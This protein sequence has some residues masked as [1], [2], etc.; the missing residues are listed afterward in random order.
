ML[1]RGRFLE[2]GYGDGSMLL[3]LARKGFVG[4]GF[5]T[6]PA[7]QAEAEEAVVRATKGRIRLLRTLD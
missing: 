3:L 2:I 6:S 4:D 7:A 1:P 5:D